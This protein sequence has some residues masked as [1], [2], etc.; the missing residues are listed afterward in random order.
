M[1]KK[2]ELKREYQQN[3]TP[4]G[5]YQIRNTINDKVFIGTALNVPGV[6]NGQKFQLSAGSHPN[7]RLQA[8]WN[9]FGGERFTF[10]ILDELSATEGPAHDYRA[11]LAFLEEFWLETLQPYGERGYNEKKRTKDEMLRLIA[12]NRISKQSK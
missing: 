12:Q 5:I 9:E 2:K 4:M 3:Q 10:E 11:D 6:L 8:E 1:R 7:K